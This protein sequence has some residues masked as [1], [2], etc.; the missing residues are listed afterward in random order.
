MATARP[1]R[2]GL[3]QQLLINGALD[4]SVLVGKYDEPA[5]ERGNWSAMTHYRE[6]IG[7]ALRTKNKVNPVYVSP[8][9]FD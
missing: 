9:H 8:G 1:T 2:A 7:A 3:V 5:P 4:E 6:V